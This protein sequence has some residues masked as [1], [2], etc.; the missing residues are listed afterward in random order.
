MSY[1]TRVLAGVAPLALLA[2]L[3]AAH[4]EPQPAT[5]SFP[6]A[7]P[8]IDTIPAPKD[9]PY[10]GGTIQLAV[11]ATDV[12]RGIFSVKEVIPVAESG[13]L[14][15]LFPK[16]LPGNHSPTG[17]VSK[18][19]G[20][21]ITADGKTIP[22]VRDTV[23]VYAFHIDVPQGAK[24]VTATFQ[25]L[26]P[27]AGNQGRIVTTP[28]MLSLQ[29][30]CV[31]LYPAGYYV[32]QIPFQASVTYPKGWKSATAL[33]P[34][35]SGDEVTYPVVDFET[36]V[37]SPTIAGRNMRSDVLA[38]G[39]RLD[40]A[41]DRPEQLAATPAQ[42]DAHKRLVEQAVKV[43]GAQHY[44]HY[45]F[46]LTLSAN[47]GGE[48]LEHHRSSEDGTQPNYFTEWDS[49][50]AQRNLLPHEF[51]HSWDGKFR[52]GADLWTPDYRTPMQDT[53]LWVYEGQTQYWGYIL[54]ARSG[55]VSKQDTLDALASTAAYYQN[56]PAKSWRTVEDTTHD[57][58][59]SRRSPQGWRNYQWSE[60]Y[61]EAG[62]L[63]WLD[64]DQ[65]IREKTGGKKSLDD[66]AR[67]FFGVR[68][69]DWG[70]LTY[71]FQDV[72]D[73]LNKVMPYDWATFLN[74]RIYDVKPE[75]TLGWITRG[76][77]KLVYQD[78]PTAYL[79]SVEKARKITD[80]SYSIGITI[81]KEGAITAVAWGSPAFDAGITIGGKL[82]A[83]NG[84]DY[85][86]DLLKSVITAAKGGT[87]PIH[88]LVKQGD[89]YRDLAIKW[90]GG[91]RYPTLEKVAKGEA[92]LDKL[93]APKS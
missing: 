18:M 66:F 41:A 67:L 52:R 63:M 17:Q 51:T 80:L 22:W 9:V 7:L 38:P 46:L 3:S 39:V 84:R 8:I 19:A 16:W 82:L 23:D 31:A 71:Q 65:L 11:D 26:S 75:A 77:Y 81:G 36:L 27:T 56:S 10:P 79:K 78:K 58:I 74:E 29:W 47:L 2:S 69:R 64:A 24:S 45:D 76:G 15:L 60:D 73:A 89:T 50:P 54:Q 62:K 92:G 70:V 53:L 44:D 32:R 25:Y 86:G 61:Y 55:L 12:T 72:V 1:L 87:Q 14:T 37:D 90:N 34:G 42:I 4:A 48:G 49:T 21:V 5:N 91:L 43:F 57:P 83:V 88:L 93:L 59:I 13:K 33:A 30:D 20:L 35:L 40:I 6:Q 28:D 68:D 85:D